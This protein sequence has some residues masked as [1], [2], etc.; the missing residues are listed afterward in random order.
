MSVHS[1]RGDRLRVARELKGLHQAELADK[2][3]V[4]SK[5]IGRW[6]LG[7][8]EPRRAILE[9]MGEVLDRDIEW[10]YGEDEE[11]AEP[12]S[13]PVSGFIQEL[14]SAS[15]LFQLI[16][17]TDNPL[18]H[19]RALHDRQL[20]ELQQVSPKALRGAREALALSIADVARMSGL[21]SSRLIDIEGSLGEPIQPSEIMALRRAL[22]VRFEPMAAA[23]SLLSLQPTKDRR[24]ARARLEESRRL[25]ESEFKRTPN[26]LDTILTRLD[27]LQKDVDELKRKVDD[28]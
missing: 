26:K 14:E 27:Q 20:T 5:S 3:G 22:G 6:E 23:F 24:P 11:P 4:A 12:R 25:W 2:L 16:T 13:L 1:F 18:D 28:R 10:F 19:D 17:A 15:R 9:R 21:P 7:Q 8:S